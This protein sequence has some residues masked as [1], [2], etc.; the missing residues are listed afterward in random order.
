MNMMGY[1]WK[2]RWR[3]RF[4]DRGIRDMYF[5]DGWTVLAC[6]VQVL[7]PL[8]IGSFFRITPY[9]PKL[10]AQHVHSDK[11]DGVWLSPEWQCWRCGLLINY[12]AGKG[13]EVA[14][15]C[16]SMLSDSR[17]YF[18]FSCVP[19]SSICLRNFHLYQACTVRLLIIL[20]L[21][22]PSPSAQTAPG[23]CRIC[24]RDTQVSNPASC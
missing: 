6:I 4:R 13:G 18:R 23:L 20:F 24:W 19:F 12:R 10:K 21:S 16:L 1:R 5:S 9:L 17:L 7:I 22:H 15:C 11:E 2:W 3:S 14:F 8:R